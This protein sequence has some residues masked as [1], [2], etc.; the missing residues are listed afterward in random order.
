[1]TSSKDE[2]WWLRH[3]QTMGEHLCVMIRRL[4]DDKEHAEL[5]MVAQLPAFEDLFS[6]TF[7]KSKADEAKETPME[8]ALIWICGVLDE[9]QID[10]KTAPIQ[11]LLDV[12]FDLK[13]NME[14]E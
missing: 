6:S 13:R 2:Q 11:E 1:M 4:L 7:E 12:L 14:D 5:L 9:C 8:D 3:Y 10:V